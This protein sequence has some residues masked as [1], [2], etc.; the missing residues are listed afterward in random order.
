MK[1]SCQH[2]APAASPPP[3]PIKIFAKSNFLLAQAMKAYGG[4]RRTFR[5]LQL[6]S[7]WGREFSSILRVGIDFE[8]V[9]V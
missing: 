2:Y 1:V 3:R 9:L 6:D 5:E 4:S 8:I 7:G